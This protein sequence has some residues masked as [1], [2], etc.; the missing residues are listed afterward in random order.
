ML[1]LT[2]AATPR[3]CC[4]LPRISRARAPRPA[5]GWWAGQGRTRTR[6]PGPA[7]ALRCKEPNMTDPEI[8]ELR[9]KVHCAVVLERTP[10]LWKLDRKEST[11][12]GLKYRRGK[13]EIL[14]WW[15]P[16]S[17]AKGDVFGL[18]QRL[19]PGLTFGHV[20]KRLREF[21]G[22]SPSSQIANRAGDNRQPDRTVAQR[23]TTRRA[24]WP[25]NSPTWRYLVRKRYLPTAIIEAASACAKPARGAS[26]QRLVRSFRRCRRCHPC[27]RAWT[28]F[29]RLADWR[30]QIAF[31]IAAQR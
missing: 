23:W 13:G 15:D 11:R 29:Q 3:V 25:P 30:S 2:P 7:P 10:P 31:S 1:P 6:G 24:V 22:L 26:W 18:V 16:M 5:R 20:R 12:L 9:G 17:D 8:E 27:R 4:R 28:Y 21:A 19:E 14:G